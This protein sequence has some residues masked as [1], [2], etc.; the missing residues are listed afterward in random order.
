MEVQMQLTRREI[1]SLLPASLLTGLIPAI[2]TAQ[3]SPL[4][5]AVYPFD[6]LP[7]RTVGDAQY[8][9]IIKGKLTTGESL[10]VHET[11]LGP[12]AIPHPPHH[13]SHT[14]F[15]VIREG[16]VELTVNGKSSVIGPG[17]LGFAASNDVHGIKNVGDTPATY[18]VV[19]IGPQSAG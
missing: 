6:K 9:A 16:T 18:F 1:C 14:E 5:S 15:W 19:A 2:A 11:T 3:D 7:V 4:A 10:E 13:H 17:S 8:R 12:H